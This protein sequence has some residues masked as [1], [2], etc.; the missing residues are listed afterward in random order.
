MAKKKYYSHRSTYFSDA[1]AVSDPA[2]QTNQRAVNDYNIAEK[3]GFYSYLRMICRTPA[4]I[5]D[6][7][8][9]IDKYQTGISELS[10]AKL[11]NKN[12]KGLTTDKG[13]LCYNDARDKGRVPLEEMA[14][15]WKWKPEDLAKLHED[16]IYSDFNG[17]CTAFLNEYKPLEKKSLLNNYK[18]G[19][20]TN[21]DP[22]LMLYRIEDVIFTTSSSIP[23]HSFDPH[24]LEHSD[25]SFPCNGV[26]FDLL[27]HIMLSLS[28]AG[29][30]LENGQIGRFSLAT[31]NCECVSS[32]NDFSFGDAGFYFTTL[33]L[34]ASYFPFFGTQ[35]GGTRMRV[36][37]IS[38]PSVNLL[39]ENVL[40]TIKKFFI[41]LVKQQLIPLGKL[42]FLNDS[43]KLILLP[44]SREE[45]FAYTIADC[46]NVINALDSSLKLDTFAVMPKEVFKDMTLGISASLTNHYSNAKGKISS[47]SI[48]ALK[49]IDKDELYVEILSRILKFTELILKQV[50]SLD[51]SVADTLVSKVSCKESAIEESSYTCPS[52]IV[53]NKAFKL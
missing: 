18:A 46:G 50:D 45:H 36:H 2:F 48:E 6:D 49:N 4:S 44:V 28:T 34:P 42:Y 16:S 53:T 19:R 14:R 52:R 40:D 35:F 10:D 43:E 7:L 22:Y 1:D 24:L 3:I 11:V 47:I 41:D 25:M 51:C 23:A 20:L 8:G 38:I 12:S 13:F 27:T 37:Y 39:D 9:C 5:L 26:L 29:Y 33:H 30:Y 31:S 21:V 15:R 17:T 32:K